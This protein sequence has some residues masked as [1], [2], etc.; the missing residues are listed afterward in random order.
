MKK[1]IGFLFQFVAEGNKATVLL[2]I[3]SRLTNLDIRK[4]QTFWCFE[5]V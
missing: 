2:E 4:Q 5:G 3:E 1:I